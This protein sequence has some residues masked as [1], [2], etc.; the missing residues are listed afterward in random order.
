MSGKQS[1]YW[2]TGTRKWFSCNSTFSLLCSVMGQ[3]TTEQWQKHLWKRLRNGGKIKK[4]KRSAPFGCQWQGRC[5]CFT[6][7]SNGD[8]Y[9]RIQRRLCS[10]QTHLYGAHQN[11]CQG[12]KCRRANCKKVELIVPN[13]VSLVLIISC[14]SYN[15]FELTLNM[16]VNKT[17]YK[18]MI[19]KI[20]S[21]QLVSDGVFTA[22]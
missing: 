14:F 19:H 12:C 9:K 8:K 16:Y 5:T 20:R 3:G 18:L 15:L 6:F 13:L 7:P 21:I 17:K 2:V 22:L 10:S 1:Y 11:L 4:K